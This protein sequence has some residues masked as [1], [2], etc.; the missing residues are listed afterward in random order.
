[1]KIL[2]PI[3]G[4]DCSARTVQW[5]TAT[6]NK[7]ATEYYLLIVIPVYTEMNMVEYEVLDATKLLKETRMALE[8]QGCRVAKAEYVLGE[9]VTQ[10]CDYAEEMSVD[11]VV[12]G[13][14]GRTG[15]NK[16]L[17]GSVSIAVMEH[18]KRPVSVYRNFEPHTSTPHFIP[19][20]TVL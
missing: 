19:S 2:L 9:A 10:I 14:H 11:Q 12:I 18:C 5:A 16:L 6:F 8:S 3:D 7:Q 4:S 15:F 1:M 20:G 17:L 13:S